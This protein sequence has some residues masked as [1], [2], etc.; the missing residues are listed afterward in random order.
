[1]S[2]EGSDAEPLTPLD[3]AKMR[4]VAN[5]LALLPPEVSEVD[6]VWS[7]VQPE[8][9]EGLDGALPNRRRPTPST[10]R[11]AAGKMEKLQGVINKAASEGKKRGRGG[12]PG[13][14]G[15]SLAVTISR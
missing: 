9:V 15:A 5:K 8:S 7:S 12:E 6:M 3:P 13:E 4:P 2:L 1:M 11:S 14:K 10:A